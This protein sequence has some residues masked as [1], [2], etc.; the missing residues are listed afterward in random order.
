MY[1]NWDLLSNVIRWAIPQQCVRIGYSSAMWNCWVELNNVKK[2]GVLQKSNRI[3]YT[4]HQC[5]KTVYFVN[6]IIY[7]LDLG[8]GV[9]KL[10]YG[11]AFGKKRVHDSV[12]ILRGAIWTD[13]VPHCIMK[14]C[15]TGRLNFSPTFLH[16]PSAL[17]GIQVKRSRKTHE[18]I[19]Y[20]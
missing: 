9:K 12:N 18:F 8:V 5:I 20:L 1:W 19:I 10:R 4:T 14:A 6:V 2:Q 15:R 7:G 3:A 16:K 11:W 17:F 13:F